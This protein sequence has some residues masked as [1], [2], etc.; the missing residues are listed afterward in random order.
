MKK[1]VQIIFIKLY[2]RQ[3]A[4]L[5]FLGG[6]ESFRSRSRF[7]IGTVFAKDPCRPS[8]YPFLWPPR[9]LTLE[10]AS[11]APESEPCHLLS[12]CLT[13]NK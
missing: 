5:S 3:V 10:P 6:K 13:L 7:T 11:P 1:R 9:S 2:L 8:Y 12:D 4:F